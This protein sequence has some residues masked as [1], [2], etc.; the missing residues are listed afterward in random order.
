MEKINVHFNFNVSV[1]KL[2]TYL[3]NHDNFNAIFAPAKVQTLYKGKD[4]DFGL[5][6]KRKISV[7]TFISFEETI[8]EFEENRRIA[9][10]ITKGSPLKNHYGELLFKPTDSGSTLHY[11]IQFD[12]NIP[13]IAKI[14]KRD[15]EKSIAKGFKDLQNKLH[16]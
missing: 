1:E 8:V 11:T 7:F 14:I 9:Y 15:L 2:F 6:S 16:S 3:K 4:N 10:R 12:S 13:F 5:G